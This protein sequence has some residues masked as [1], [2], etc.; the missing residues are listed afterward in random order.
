MNTHALRQQ[1]VTRVAEATSRMEAMDIFFDALAPY[2]EKIAATEARAEDI[3]RFR[4]PDRPFLQCEISDIYAKIEA[5]PCR[6]AAEGLET[7]LFWQCINIWL[8]LTAVPEAD[9]LP[10]LHPN[11]GT[12]DFIPRLYGAEFTV[13]PDYSVIPEAFLIHDLERDL[14]RLPRPPAA[15]TPIGRQLLASYRFLLDATEARLPIAYPQLQG[16][17]TNAVRLMPQE[18]YLMAVVAEPELARALAEHITQSMLEIMT[19]IRTTMGPDDHLLRARTRGCQPPWVKGLM[20]DDYISVVH[21]QQYLAVTG[22]SWQMMAETLGPIFLHTCGPVMQ[23]AE[24]LCALPGLAGFETSFLSGFSKTTAELTTLKAALAG[25][26]VLQSF[27]LPHGE[28]VHDEAYLTAE[29]LREISTGGGF[30]LLAGGTA[31]QGKA[32]LRKLELEDSE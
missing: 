5:Q 7:H 22:T 19:A 9:Y 30:M 24:I 8:M 18:E 31:E 6:W 3:Y 21:P 28:T 12:P 27:A 15:E 17:T 2:A 20:V 23:A 26:V 29:W 4:T 14:P 10:M 16:P 1:T 25:K 11:W 32:L 13:L